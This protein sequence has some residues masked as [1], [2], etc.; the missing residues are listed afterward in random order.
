MKTLPKEDGKRVAFE[1]RRE[2]NEASDDIAETAFKESAFKL[3]RFGTDHRRRI[4]KEGTGAFTPRRSSFSSASD[5]FLAS[6]SPPTLFGGK[7]FLRGL[8]DTCFG[9]ISSWCAPVPPNGY[10]NP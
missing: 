9:H 5:I 8:A 3:P 6:D 2:V 1:Q 7:N 10:V 4:R